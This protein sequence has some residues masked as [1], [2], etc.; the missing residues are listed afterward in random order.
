MMRKEDATARET[1]GQ[2]VEDA[3][4]VFA[5]IQIA[6]TKLSEGETDQG[7]S[8]L[9]EALQLVETVPQMVSRASILVGVAT[10]FNEARDKEKSLQAA[11]ECIAVIGELRD[12][13]AQAT[14]L[15]ELGSLYSEAGF[16]FGPE[17]HSVVDRLLVKADT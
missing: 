5:L 16:E 8:L 15:A 13:A 2:I 9:D 3:D 14:G 1:I 12:E 7:I 11:H 10:R 17:E 6:D 4:R